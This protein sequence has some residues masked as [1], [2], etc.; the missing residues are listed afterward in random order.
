[1]AAAGM[2]LENLTRCEPRTVP[3]GEPLEVGDDALCA[4]IVSV[5]QR[6]AAKRREPEAEDGADIA[7]ARAPDHVLAERACGFIHNP[8]HQ[9]LHDL[10]GTG[11]AVG[12]DTEQGV[13]AFVD[14][15]LLSA[16]V[17]VEPAPG[18]ATQP[19]GFHERGNAGSGSRREP[20]AV[21]FLHHTRDLERD[22][23]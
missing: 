17:D 13:D 5:A 23:E 10:G 6:P 8:Q 19:A 4:E 3:L 12:M 21:G 14:A 18:L 11:T 22:V 20:I 1:G 16:L 9:A 2:L 7:V 15:P